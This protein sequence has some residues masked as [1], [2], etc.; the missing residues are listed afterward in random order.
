MRE[1]SAA[2]VSAQK[3][4]AAKIAGKGLPLVP[5]LGFTRVVNGFSARSIRAAS[6]C[7]NGTPSVARR[8]PDA[9]RLSGL[10]LVARARA[11]DRVAQPRADAGRLRRQGRDRRACSTRGST[12]RI[13]SCAAASTRASTSSR[14][15]ASPRRRST[16]GCPPRSSGTGRSSPGS[17]PARTGPAGCAGSRPG[18][19]SCRSAS[20]AGSRRSSGGYAIYGR[21]DQ[22]LAGIERAVDP[23]GDGSVLDAA[24]IALVGVAEPFAAF[25]SSALAQAV[26]GAAA[27]DTLV[28]A[29]AGNDGPAGPA[30]GSIAGTG[31]RSRRARGRRRRRPRRRRNGAGADARRPPR[32]ARPAAA[33]R[34]RRR[35]AP[36]PDAAARGP[37]A[38]DPRTPSDERAAAG[39][40]D[41]RGYSLVAGRAALVAPGSTPQTAQRDAA[42]AGA[43]AV[44]V[45]GVTPAG[46]LGL[47]ER[48]EV[49]VVGVPAEIARAARRALAAGIAVTVSIGV[50]RSAPNPAAGRIAPF[51]SRGLAYAGGGKPELVATGIAVATA[52][53]GRNE[54]GTAHYGT[55]NGTSAAAAVVAGSAALLAGARPALD[56]RALRGALVGDRARPRRT[57]SGRGGRRSARP[58]R[59]GG[60]RSRLPAGDALV[61]PRLRARCDRGADARDPERLLAPPR[62]R[63]LGAAAGRGRT[64]PSGSSRA[65]SRSHVVAAVASG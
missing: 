49:P 15:K 38:G 16:R 10:A 52:E 60:G 8:L 23:N 64:S 55:V 3:Q 5:E 2:A 14:R 33:A 46:A 11:D 47:D 4:F 40:F 44:I 54:D 39:F 21:T 36:R 43:A 28:V 63:T 48:V 24:R 61:R 34:R 35:P 65:S 18:P 6:P 25:P 62:R 50:P 17:S 22:V 9:R 31:R 13:R 58:D 1:W 53:P 26:A 32:P 56:A 12:R 41:A 59:R 30:Y 42:L 19:G 29:P 51:S 7:S 20:R 57:R 37:R 45:P 27:L